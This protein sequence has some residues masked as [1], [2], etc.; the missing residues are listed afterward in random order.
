MGKRERPFK[1]IINFRGN[2]G[3]PEKR[4]YNVNWIVI[5]CCWD[6]SQLCLEVVAVTF[7]LNILLHPDKYDCDDVVLMDDENG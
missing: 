1:R 6:R 7:W 3:S 2:K 4:N 5:E